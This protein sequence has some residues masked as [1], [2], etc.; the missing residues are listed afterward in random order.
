MSREIVEALKGAIDNSFDMVAKYI[1]ICPDE[2]WA[3]TNGGW[4]VWQQI[5]HLLGAVDFFVDA[6]DAEPQPGLISAECGGLRAVSQ[7]APIDKATMKKVWQ[8]AKAKA[9]AFAEAL[10]DAD[11]TKQNEGVLA[12]ANWPIS[13]A[14]TLSMLSSHTQYHLGSCDNALRDHGMEGVF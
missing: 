4:P 6:A 11:L 1:D 14:A 9:D 7:D 3:E 12:R 5:Y 10:T 13:L 8:N 2:I